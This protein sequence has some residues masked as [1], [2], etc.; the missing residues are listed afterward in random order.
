ME[1]SII[2]SL[3]S[4]FINALAGIAVYILLQQL[5]IIPKLYIQEKNV[6]L[7][8]QVAETFEVM[9]KKYNK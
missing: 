5:G 6:Y 2:K 4:Y 8:S 9:P 1:S 7:D 3:I